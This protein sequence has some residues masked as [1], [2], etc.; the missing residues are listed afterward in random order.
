MSIVISFIMTI[1]NMIVI[2]NSSSIAII[3]ISIRPL[4][5]IIIVAIILVSF[6]L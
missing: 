6:L 1:N 4:T 5:A 2:I 3:M